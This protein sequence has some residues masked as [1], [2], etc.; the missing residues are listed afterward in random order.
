MD[1]LPD[2][3]LAGPAALRK[4]PVTTGRLLFVVGLRNEMIEAASDLEVDGRA[5]ARHD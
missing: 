3:H 5:A 1:R 2:L 4:R